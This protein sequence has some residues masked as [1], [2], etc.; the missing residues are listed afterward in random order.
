MAYTFIGME[1][2]FTATDWRLHFHTLATCSCR[3]HVHCERLQPCHA[4]KVR[5]TYWPEMREQ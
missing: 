5:K 1:L 3:N 2:I 4:Y